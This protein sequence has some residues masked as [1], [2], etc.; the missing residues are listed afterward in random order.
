MLTAKAALRNHLTAIAKQQIDQEALAQA[1]D[2][3]MGT[4]AGHVDIGDQ[5]REQ[6]REAIAVVMRDRA[7][8]E[9]KILTGEEAPS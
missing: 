7:A 5:T 8:N 9:P 3:V 1:V 6:I 4:L 2:V